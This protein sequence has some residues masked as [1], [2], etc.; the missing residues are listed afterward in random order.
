MPDGNRNEEFFT[1]EYSIS[2]QSDENFLNLQSGEEVL[3]TTVEVLNATDLYTL[4]CESVKFYFM[5]I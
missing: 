4:K 3:N 1:S 2:T 5:F